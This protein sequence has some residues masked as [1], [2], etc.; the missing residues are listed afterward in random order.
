M[1]M[2]LKRSHCG[3]PGLFRAAEGILCTEIGRRL[4]RLGSGGPLV[5][6]SAGTLPAASSAM[7][8]LSCSDGLE[9]MLCLL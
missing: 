5:L 1:L 3:A 2:S 8:C 6:T 4:G 7:L 9:S